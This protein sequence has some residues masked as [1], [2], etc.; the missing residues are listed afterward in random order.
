MRSN[1][2]PDRDGVTAVLDRYRASCAEMAARSLD[3]LTTPEW[4][5]V[6]D[7]VETGR[8]MMPVVEH[9]AITQIAEHAVPAEIGGPLPQVLADRL[10]ITK[11]E[12]SRRIKDAERLG[13]RTSFAGEPLAPW[14]PA[15]A[16]AQRAGEIG[17]GHISEIRRFFKQ[18]PGWVDEPSRERA[19]RDLAKLAREYRPDE[20]RVMAGRMADAINPD[21]LFSDEDRARKRGITIGRQD[22]D[23]MS[24]IT[25]HLSPGAARRDR[26]RAGQAGRPRHV[27][28]RGPKPGHRW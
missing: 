1:E 28:P 24:P 12:A 3:A 21:G 19:E 11:A 18:L 23:G 9:Q 4:F 13:P 6:L 22:L 26:R 14:W 27:Q 10:R 5:S 17:P 20:L 7:V 15:T 25:G 8:R 16:A 2:V